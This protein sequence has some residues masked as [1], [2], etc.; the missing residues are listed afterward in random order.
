MR[1]CIACFAISLA[2]SV[3]AVGQAGPCSG[4][5]TGSW[6]LDVEKSTFGPI[7]VP[8]VPPNLTVVAQTVKIDCADGKIRLSGE[9]TV[10]LSGQAVTSKDDLSLALDGTA[11]DIGPARLAFRLVGAFEFE[12][13]SNLKLKDKEYEEVSRFAFSQ[14]GKL[15]S[16]TKTQTERAGASDGGEMGNGRPTKSSTSVL[17]FAR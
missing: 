6:T 10:T 7:L 3:H 17:I 14:D 1:R 13:V 4:D 16:E 2:L 15:L 8:G 12:I 9:T 5:W 11:T